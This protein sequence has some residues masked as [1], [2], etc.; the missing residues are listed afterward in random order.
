[1]KTAVFQVTEGRGRAR[2][3]CVLMPSLREAA[4]LEAWLRI[5]ADSI[6]TSGFWA[7]SMRYKRRSGSRKQ[8]N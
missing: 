1:M 5:H 2:L 3:I 6:T 8:K 4:I 7:G